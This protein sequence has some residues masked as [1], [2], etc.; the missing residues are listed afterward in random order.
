M[1]TNQV[2]LGGAA[3]ILAGG[4]LF[5]SVAWAMG[6]VNKVEFTKL[7]VGFLL[8]HGCIWVDLSY[9]L[10]WK[11]AAQI[12]EDLSKVAL[13]EII[14]VAFIYC[15]KSLFENM[16]KNNV[17]PDKPVSIQEFNAREPMDGGDIK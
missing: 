11:G 13:A 10:A 6:R 17:W 14:A 2:I 12:A 15:V 8:V 7:V 9:G 4:L 1:S 5:A 16:S 3:C